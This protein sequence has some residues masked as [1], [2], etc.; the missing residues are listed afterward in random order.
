MRKIT[1]QEFLNRLVMVHGDKYI[2]LSGYINTNTKVRML[3]KHCNKEFLIKPSKLFIGQGCPHCRAE[4][5]GISKTFTQKQFEDMVHKLL[6]D[7]YIVLSKYKNQN[8]LIT[9][10]H[11]SCNTT[12]TTR[13]TNIINKHRGCPKCTC[14]E[15]N[16]SGFKY[17]DSEIRDKIKEV[18]LD[19]YELLQPY[20]NAKTKH[21]FRH[22]ECGSEFMMTVQKFLYGQRCPYCQHSRGEDK[23]Y[24]L[25]INHSNYKIIPQYKFNDLRS[26]KNYRNIL[27]FDFAVFDNNVLICLIEYD[28]E[29]HFNSVNC[30]GKDKEKTL[31][32][33]RKRDALKD[34]YCIKHGYKLLRIPYTEYTNIEQ[35]L[36]DNK[37][38][39]GE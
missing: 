15:V 11:L 2:Y 25:L 7:D 35:I 22:K 9:I 20:T 32:E 18:S 14:S 4:R 19:E 24:S 33:C 21:L 28:G 30:F 5:I 12:Y 8:S 39:K 29:Q 23:I 17:T 6:G 26:G 13:A 34:D 27:R 16:H 10:K 36:K 38:I 37:L 1:E 3:C 31:E